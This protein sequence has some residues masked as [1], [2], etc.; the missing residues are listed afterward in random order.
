MA[1]LKVPAM[2]SPVQPVVDANGTMSR[3]WYLVIEYLV[4][5]AVIGPANAVADGATVKFDGTTGRN[6]KQ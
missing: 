5:N 3:P 6:V 1:P 2:P 4:K